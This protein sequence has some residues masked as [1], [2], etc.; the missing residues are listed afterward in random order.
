LSDRRTRDQTCSLPTISRAISRAHVDAVYP[1]KRTS[2]DI[3]A[4]PT[5][6]DLV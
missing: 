5:L 4:P 1:R 3:F 2:N 6:C